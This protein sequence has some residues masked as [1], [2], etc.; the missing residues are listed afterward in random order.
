V[1]FI[2]AEG[3]GGDQTVEGNGHRRWSVMMVVE[4]VVSGGD[5]LGSDE[6][7]GGALAILGAE[8][9]GAP[10]GDS[11]RVSWRRRRG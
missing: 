9:G 5:W 2:G 7:G 1:P 4:A 3:E 6:G 11:A 10:G 8:G